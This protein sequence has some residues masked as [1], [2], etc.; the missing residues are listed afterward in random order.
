MII[1]E[2]HHKAQE[3]LLSS[4]DTKQLRKT[5]QFLYFSLTMDE[6][7]KNLLPE[8][9]DKMSGDTF[10]LLEFSEKIEEID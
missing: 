10:L 6:T 8:N 9:F 7:N 1:T 4:C 5:I 2:T 3:D